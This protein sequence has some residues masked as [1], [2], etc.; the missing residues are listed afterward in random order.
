[1]TVASGAELTSSTSSNIAMRGYTTREAAQLAAI[2]PDRVRS[3]ARAG[4][5]DAEREAASS[6]YRYSFRDIV[7]LRAARELEQAEV[8]ARRIH[9]AL[10]A[11]R[12]R[13]PSR[14][15]LTG[16]RI[17]AEGDQVLVR[18]QGKLWQPETGQVTFDFTVHDL[19][20]DA[21]P[22]VIA[23]ADAAEEDIATTAE[24]WF[25]LGLDLESVD[26]ADRAIV[27]YAQAIALDPRHADANINLG[28]LLHDTGDVR[29]AEQCYRRALASRPEHPTARF[30]LGVALEDQ[31]RHAEAIAA[32]ELAL[33]RD[34]NHADTHFNLSR[35]YEL[36][37]DRVTAFRHLRRYRDL[38]GHG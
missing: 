31:G 26:E 3:F 7:L 27:A 30:N 32:Y 36:A 29:D 11:L 33:A 2:S 14:Q 17:T 1:M 28:R 37:G 23:S 35:L 4:L 38:T 12:Q 5:L 21:A 34:P 18:E 24:D 22:L 13:L 19:A 20:A 6:Q 9:A 15:P 16:V 10:R 25:I 8:P